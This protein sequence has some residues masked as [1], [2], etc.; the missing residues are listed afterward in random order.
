[1]KKLSLLM[2]AFVATL[3]LAFAGETPL[4]GTYSK[5]Y[6]F[7][8][9]TSLAVSNAFQVDFAFSDN[10][11]VDVTVPDFIQPYLKVTCIGNRVRIG[12]EKL[13]RDVQRKLNDLKDP[14]QAT[15]RMP[16]LLS[17]TLSGAVRL[18]AEGEQV[19]TNENL[20]VDLSGSS[21]LQTLVSSGNGTLN[22]EVSGASKAELKAD[23]SV[24]NIDL[25]GASKLELEGNSGKVN[26]DCSGASGC[27]IDGKVLS[28]NA[29]LSGSSKLR[30]NGPVGNLKLDQSGA[31][32]FT[33]SEEIAQA[34]VEVSG[35]SSCHVI[36]TEQLTYEL[37][38]ASTLHVKNMGGASVTGEQSRGSK[39]DF[40][41]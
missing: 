39:I 14:L 2:L 26:I 33:A 29:D 11:T 23:F 4:K 10:W 12:L 28:M 22:L 25:S 34:H 16:K 8:D 37:S 7:R 18:K 38:G 3:T 31:S 19:L 40:V 1:M 21:K 20:H 30:L 15:V 36:V 6:D 27:A 32:K 17:L 35:A 13:P 41:R 9:F 5:H 24:M